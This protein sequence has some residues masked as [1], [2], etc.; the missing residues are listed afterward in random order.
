MSM[1]RR[2][3]DAFREWPFDVGHQL[4]LAHDYDLPDEPSTVRPVLRAVDTSPRPGSPGVDGP[5]APVASGAVGQP[6]DWDGVRRDLDHL[7]SVLTEALAWI[8]ELDPTPMGL[9]EADEWAWQ[10]VTRIRPKR[11]GRQSRT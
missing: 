5:T 1:F 10:T 8:D 6:T 11:K 3:A 2:I 7:R 9:A 4:A